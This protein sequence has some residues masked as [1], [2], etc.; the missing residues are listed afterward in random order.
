MVIWLGERTKCFTCNPQGYRILFSIRSNWLRIICPHPWPVPNIWI[1]KKNT[2]YGNKK[3]RLQLYEYKYKYI[4]EAVY[5]AVLITHDTHVDETRHNLL[6]LNVRFWKRHCLCYANPYGIYLGETRD[7]D[8]MYKAIV[9]CLVGK[10]FMICLFY[11]RF[12]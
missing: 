11:V 6:G 8:S 4:I 9:T 5:H 10:W 2:N 7:S 3:Q 12:S 1:F